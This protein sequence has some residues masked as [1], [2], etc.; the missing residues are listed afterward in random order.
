VAE[1]EIGTVG[2]GDLRDRLSRVNPT[3][4]QP[5]LLPPD[6]TVF[7]VRDNGVGFSMEYA[8]KLF[9]VFQRLHL[10]EEFEG[11]GVGLAT[12]RRII[13]KHGGFVWAESQ[14]DQGATFYFTIGDLLD[15]DH[16]RRNEQAELVEEV[17]A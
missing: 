17:R 9:G 4:P 6:S 7:Y 13:E 10:S 5:A 14:L 15:G 3:L 1:I 16:H 8:D 12:V 2:Y 11:T